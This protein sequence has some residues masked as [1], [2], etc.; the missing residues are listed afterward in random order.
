MNC[1]V[2]FASPAHFAVLFLI[3]MFRLLALL[4]GINVEDLQAHITSLLSRTHIEALIHGNVTKDVSVPTLDL[5]VSPLGDV[6]ASSSPLM[7]TEILLSVS[8]LL[9]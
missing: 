3:Y 9:T 4:I 7:L 2:R 5:L 6:G 8:R 1:K